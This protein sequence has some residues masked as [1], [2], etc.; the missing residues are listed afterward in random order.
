MECAF[1][2]IEDAALEIFDGAVKQ[3]NITI[4]YNV[5]ALH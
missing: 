3:D 5:N 1:F 4:N 2:Q